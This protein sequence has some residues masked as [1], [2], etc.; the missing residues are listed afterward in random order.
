M[1]KIKLIDSLEPAGDFKIAQSKDIAYNGVSVE[2]ALNDQISTAEQVETNTAA[3][4]QNT[5]EVNT[6]SAKIET[7]TGKVTAAETAIAGKASQSEVDSI[8]T[9][10]AGKASQTEVETIKTDVAGKASAEAVTQL[11]TDM[12]VQTARMDQLVGTV[13]EGSADEIADA[14]VTA[15]GKTEANLGNAIRTQISGLKETI[16]T[17]SNNGLVFNLIENEYVD[18]NGNIEPYNFW[19]RTDYID[20]S[21]YD[22]IYISWDNYTDYA[23]WYDENKAFISRCIIRQGEPTRLIVPDDARYI[24]ISQ[25]TPKMSSLKIYAYTS[26]EAKYNAIEINDSIG[27]VKPKYNVVNNYYIG[28][29]GRIV[30]YADWFYTSPIQLDKGDKIVYKG[31]SFNVGVISKVTDNGYVSVVRSSDE[32]VK[33]YSYVADE[34]C[35]VAV[36]GKDLEY[37]H[38]ESENYL[39][40][41]IN[42]II[43]SVD[44][45]IENKCKDAKFETMDSGKWSVVGCNVEASSEGVLTATFNRAN[46]FSRV[47]YM[48]NFKAGHTYFIYSEVRSQNYVI[49]SHYIE[50]FSD[51]FEVYKGNKFTSVYSLHTPSK[52]CDRVGFYVNDNYENTVGNTYEMKKPIIVDITEQFGEVVTVGGKVAYTVGKPNQY[53][54]TDGEIN[55]YNGYF[56]SNPIKV[57]KNSE[58]T[59]VATDGSGSF[60]MLS[61]CDENGDNINVLVKYYN[62]KGEAKTITAEKDMYIVVSGKNN[63]IELS[64]SVNSDPFKYL[65]IAYAWS[66]P[67]QK[68][69][70]AF[71]KDNVS[72]YRYII[73]SADSAEVKNADIICNGI[74][75][76]LIINYVLSKLN[77]CSLYFT[78][79]SVFSISGPIIP[80]NG[81]T[82]CSNGAKFIMCDAVVKIADKIIDNKYIT[83]DDVSDFVCGQFLYVADNHQYNVVKNIYPTTSQIELDVAFDYGTGYEFRTAS[84]AIFLS[85]I[86]DIVIDGLHI[87]LNVDHNPIQPANPWY[88][89]EGITLDYTKNVTVK[90]CKICNGGRRGITTYDATHFNIINNYFDNWYEHSIDI[91]C[92]YNTHGNTTENPIMCY[93]VITG[94][95]CENN[96]MSGIQCHRGSGCT[97]SNNIIRNVLHGGVRCQEY[98]HDNVI[99]GNV[100]ENARN[101]ILINAYNINCTGNDIKNSTSSAINITGGSKYVNAT[102]NTI[103]GSAESAVFISES[104]CCHVSENIIVN[105]CSSGE[106]S[107]HIAKSIIALG[108]GL[109][110]SNNVINNNTIVEEPRTNMPDHVYYNSNVSNT[111]NHFSGNVLIGTDNMDE[112][113]GK[114]D[115]VK[116]SESDDLSGV[117][118]AFYGDSITY[119]DGHRYGNGTKEPDKIC[120]GYQ[121]WLKEWTGCSYDNRGVSG[122]TL[123]QICSRVKSGNYSDVDVIMVTGGT[124]DSLKGIT[125]GS[126]SDVGTEFDTNTTCGALQSAIEY[127]VSTY[128]EKT[129][130]LATPIKGWH[131]RNTSEV[132][133][134]TRYVEMYKQLGEL[135]SIPVL[136]WYNTSGLNILNRDTYYCDLSTSNFILHPNDEGNKL[137][138]EKLL[139]Y[140]RQFVLK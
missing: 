95:I 19:S 80:K 115:V 119:D 3:I 70:F 79:D 98:A 99:S 138:A 111:K 101:G 64:I 62:S 123:P 49:A 129:I 107:G 34:N 41:V 88:L 2:K 47:E 45:Q 8:K 48:Y 40:N 15:D 66:D 24:C 18:E 110:A 21:N 31:S 32:D 27:L 60:G 33:I 122:E 36:S 132:Q 121:S 96:H 128:P 67:S 135:Y 11:Q 86:H 137:L 12:S 23:A 44:K 10:V 83:V 106:T 104:D 69:N 7:L 81:V 91:F 53:I 136:D 51:K 50:E 65:K 1:G 94:N 93:G 68:L 37:I 22:R 42:G 139:N 103:T 46:N 113:Y 20:V 58:I 59:I 109:G 73:A 105:S 90:N 114:T 89:Q 140:T 52:D 76:Q 84:P 92:D 85:N 102:G 112:I 5:E 4:A 39:P 125:F 97:I 133:V 77:N 55:N 100:I 116:E 17:I 14:R 72:A 75:D 43:S 87:D 117:K 78:D 127:L 13:P 38:I 108:S 124:N 130:W 134:E 54:S 131:H 35:R 6:Q 82:L 26:E 120:K 118:I 16:D 25:S 126:V 29:D 56:I 63:G 61:S 28:V 74:N 71:S 57:T 9:D 30:L